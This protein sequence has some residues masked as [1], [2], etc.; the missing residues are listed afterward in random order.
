MQP[1]VCG[2]AIAIGQILLRNGQARSIIERRRFGIQ[3]RQ[4]FFN[5]GRRHVIATQP[6]NMQACQITKIACVARIGQ[7]FQLGHVVI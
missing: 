2:I 1:F 6:D 5:I 4:I 7:T 3:A